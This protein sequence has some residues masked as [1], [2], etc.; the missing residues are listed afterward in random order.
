[1]K[2]FITAEDLRRDYGR[3]TV[4]DC[5]ADLSDASYGHRVYAESRLPGAL[6]LDMDTDLSASDCVRGGGRHPLPDMEDFAV[7]LAALGVSPKDEVVIYDDWIFAA[8]RLRWMLRYVGFERVK[9]LAGGLKA[10]LAVGG[11]LETGTPTA[12]RVSVSREDAGGG[13]PLFLREEMRVD[14]EA[15]RKISLEKSRLLIDARGAARYRGDTE[16]IDRVAGHIPGA[17]NLYYEL[18]YTETGL[19]SERE[20]ETIFASLGTDGERPVVY[21][22]SGISAPVLMMALEEAGIETALYPGSYSDWSS[23]EESDIEVGEGR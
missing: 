6:F 10:W 16:P 20:L 18:P 12:R 7:T 19:K 11:E 1:M 4:I 5:R 23:R 2:C 15:V 3:Y 22:G 14:Y 13:I 21:C 8:G 9:V 17:V